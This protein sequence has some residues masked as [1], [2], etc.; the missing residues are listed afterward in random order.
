[1]LQFSLI[2]RPD[3][4]PNKSGLLTAGLGVAT[5]RAIRAVTGLAVEV[6]WPNDVMLHGR[7]IAGMLVESTLMGSKIDA[8]ICGIGINVHL[9]DAE[10]PDDLKDRATSIAIELDRAGTG[11]APPRAQLLGR[12][13]S[14]V[15]SRYDAITGDARLLLAEATELSCVL[16]H[17]VVVRS[18]DGSTIQGR[19]ESFD[20][21]GALRVV[22]DGTSRALHVGE[23]E[24]LRTA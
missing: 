1:L 19:A 10:I 11:T 20:P 13:V 14:E 12:I 15:E 16:G 3:L 17:D 4:D 21:D 6:K 18:A 7:K 5:A 8:A 24:Q 2:L 22:V 9:S 23:I